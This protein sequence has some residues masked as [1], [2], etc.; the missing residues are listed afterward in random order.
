MCM[1]RVSPQPSDPFWLS[2]CSFY[3][4]EHM[5]LLSGANRVER[6]RDLE[7][8]L[9]PALRYLGKNRVCG[10]LTVHVGVL[11]KGLAVLCEVAL[12]WWWG[13]LVQRLDV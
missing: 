11:Y 2:S 13:L 6:A 12:S 8:W 10:E 5:G 4:R 3:V 7:W 9:E 1:F